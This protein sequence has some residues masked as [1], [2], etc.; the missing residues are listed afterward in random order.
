MKRLSLIFLSMVLVA[1]AAPGRRRT[2][3]LALS[4]TDS[5]TAA[6]LD[7]VNVRRHATINDYSMIGFQYGIGI[8]KM[9]FN[10]SK[11]QSSLITPANF[12]LVYTH[13]GKMFGFMPY[14]G[15]QLMLSYGQDGYKTKFNEQTQSRPDVDGAYEATYD[16]VEAA[17][18]AHMHFDVGNNFKLMANLGPYGGYRYHVER[19]GGESMD[20]AYASAF[21]DYDLKFDYG[22]RGG[23]GFGLM[24]DPLEFHVTA[25]LRW[26]FGSIYEPDYNSEY[27]YRFAYPLD[28]VI[29]AGVHLQL[30]KRSGKTKAALRKA[31]REMVFDAPPAEK[32]PEEAVDAK[33]EGQEK[34]G[35]AAE[36]EGTEVFEEINDKEDGTDQDV[37]GEGR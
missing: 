3:T 37:D 11:K 12:G 9:M 29:Q 17:A 13:Y 4:A 25:Q 31:A 33:P 15:Y 6:Y 19:T 23:V 16:Y 30:T 28:V 10:P 35:E 24:F 20:P 22:I 21:H 26:S 18:M 7:T 27:Y 2:D 36:V 5:L 34:A 32:E 8:N 14:F 1:T